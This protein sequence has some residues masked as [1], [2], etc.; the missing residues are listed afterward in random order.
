MKN[1]ISR[2]FNYLRQ[3]WFLIVMVIAIT[4]IILLFE[5]FS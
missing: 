1:F 3:E 4:V 2:F 5:L